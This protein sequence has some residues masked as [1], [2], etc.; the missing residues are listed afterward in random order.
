MAWLHPVAASDDSDMDLST[1]L[2][3]EVAGIAQANACSGL[4]LPAAA[5]GSSAAARD[6]PCV[7]AQVAVVASPSGAVASA[8][9]TGVAQQTTATPLLEVFP[10]LWVPEVFVR[11]LLESAVLQHFGIIR[12]KTGLQ[13]IC[14]LRLKQGWNG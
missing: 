1:G 8:A 4:G 11:D 5:A 6:T 12:A 7:A 14:G 2:S 10:S 9:P 3:Q 13:P